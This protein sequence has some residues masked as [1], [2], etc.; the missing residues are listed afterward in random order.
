ME[1]IIVGQF[2]ATKV[3]TFK[4]VKDG[5]LFLYGNDATLPYPDYLID[6]YQQSPKHH[7][8]IEAKVRYEV[9]GGWTVNTKGDNVQRK[10]QAQ[11][12]INNANP[13]ESL[14]EVWM[15]LAKD[16]EIF[17]GF[18]IECIW[19]KGGSAVAEIYQIP[20]AKVRLLKIDEK[21]IKYIY[22]DSWIGVTKY[23]SAKTKPGFKEWDEF[24]KVKKGSELLYIRAPRPEKSGESNVYPI[25]SYVAAIPY[26]EVD[27]EIANFHLNN[28]KNQFWGGQIVNFN[29]GTPTVEE[30]RAISNKIVNRKTGTD[31]AGRFILSFNKDT[32]SAVSVTPLTPSDLDKQFEILNKQVQ[33]E[34]FIAHHVV[35]PMLFGIRVEGQLGGRSELMDAYDLFSST[36][37]LPKQKFFESIQNYIYSFNGFGKDFKLR[38]VSPLGSGFSQGFITNYLPENFIEK[39]VPKEVITQMV[40]N[41]LGIDDNQL[42]GAFGKD[43]EDGLLLSYF[44]SVGEITETE[45]VLQTFKVDIIDGQP[46]MTD[47]EYKESYFADIRQYNI[48][49][50]D[51][52]ILSAIK[53]NPKITAKEI[54]QAL[55]LDIDVVRSRIESM[56]GAGLLK[57]DIGSDWQI[58]KKGEKA[59]Q[60]QDVLLDISVK[61]KYSGPVDSKNRPFCSELMAKSNAGRTWTR[62]EIDRI[63]NDQQYNRNAWIYRGGFYT[64]KNTDDT[65]PYCRHSWMAVI[66]KRKK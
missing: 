22:L 51:A 41:S 9:G 21:T 19:N 45:N 52:N 36:Y 44:E 8:I 35:S 66:I 34:I 39:Y 13:S 57:G 32:A 55:E 6:I 31:N 48:T 15:K 11:N 47:A 25:P 50:N 16:D 24:G 29:N 38:P 46:S 65:T 59:V 2:L 49:D 7:S 27:A 30:Q 5:Q 58:S 26:M 63:K 40:Y 54:S 53:S 61:Y 64:R 10:S 28:I 4:E 33:E 37:I 14:D 3:P 18:A 56:Q 20:F 17:G 1:N 23:E 12:V 60:E 62:D 42:N 43:S